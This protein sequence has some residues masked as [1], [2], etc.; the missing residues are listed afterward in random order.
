MKWARKYSETSSNSFGLSPYDEML[1]YPVTPIASCSAG[2]TARADVK[3]RRR[4]GK[5]AKERTTEVCEEFQTDGEA[6]AGRG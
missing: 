1:H 5:S 3:S 6:R 2:D 4:G